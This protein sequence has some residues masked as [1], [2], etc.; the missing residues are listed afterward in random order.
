[1]HV[2]IATI[3]NRIEPVTKGI[4]A[5]SPGIDRLYLLASE[6]FRESAERVADICRDLQIEV[7]IRNVSG[8][9]FQEIVNAISSIHEE[10]DGRGVL[11]SI[12]ITGGTNLMAAAACSSAFFFGATIYYVKW[13]P[14]GSMADQLEEIPVP[15]VPNVSAIKGKTREILIHILEETEAGR[16]VSNSDVSKRFDIQKQNS[17]YHLR[18]LES[19]GLIV[20]ERDPADRRHNILTLTRQGRLIAGWMRSHKGDR[21]RSGADVRPDEVADQLPLLGH[22]ILCVANDHQSPLGAGDGGVDD[23]QPGVALFGAARRR[24]PPGGLLRVGVAVHDGDSHCNTPK[25]LPIAEGFVLV[26]Q[27]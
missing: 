23:L 6:R 8:F 5:I 11:F 25:V 26:A 9:D 19:D 2:H 1:M 24:E 27:D 3:G 10:N 20:R 18:V 21:S 13:D 22:P 17:G 12:N 16:S 14:E 4:N 7:E 15:N